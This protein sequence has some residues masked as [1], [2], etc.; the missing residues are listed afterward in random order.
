MEP[1]RAWKAGEARQTPVGTP[2]QGTWPATYWYV[3]LLAGRHPEAEL[4][5][6]I[7]QI[8]DHLGRYRDFFHAIRAEGGSAE[9]FIGWFFER[10]SGDTL[11]YE[12]LAKAGDLRVDLSFDVYPPTQPQNEYEIGPHDL[13]T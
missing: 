3:D 7:N 2:L 9:L 12:T 8:L 10:Q 1:R 13:A 5:A 6:G 4:H 11:R